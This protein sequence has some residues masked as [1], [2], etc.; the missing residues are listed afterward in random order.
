MVQPAA[1]YDNDRL[2]TA[3]DLVNTYDPWSD[4]PEALPDTAALARF[5]SAHGYGSGADLTEADPAQARTLRERLRAVFSTDDVFLATQ[6]LAAA[7]AGAR[8]TA[9]PSVFE[10]GFA[11]LA[12]TSGPGDPPVTRMAADTAIALTRALERLGIERLRECAASPC[13]EAFVD[14]SRNGSRRFCSHRCANR[15]NVAAYRE[16]RRAT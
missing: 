8:I 6:E 9:V 11:Y 3:V 13:Q 10:S 7:M 1:T 14:T 5:L 15:T 2:A 16:R 4:D 12:V